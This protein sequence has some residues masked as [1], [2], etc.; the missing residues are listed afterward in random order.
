MDEAPSS[1]LTYADP[2][3]YV[4]ALMGAAF[5]S[6]TERGRVWM[7]D[8]DR[9][10]LL[11]RLS[12]NHIER[13]RPGQSTATVLT[14]PT[15]RIIDLLTVY[16]LDDALLL[17]TSPGRGAAIT[18]YL[19]K[20]SFFN[21]KVQ[22]EDATATLGQLTLYGPQAASLLQ[23]LG[24]AGTTLPAHSI[25][26]T[27]W[28]E[29]PLYLARD[30]DLGESSFWVLAPPAPLAELT[31]ALREAGAH[32]L[33]AATHEVLRVEAGRGAYGRELSLEYLPLEAGLRYAMSFTKGCYVGQEIIARMENRGRL[34]RCLRGLRLAAPPILA[35]DAPLATLTAADTA[36]G[37]LTSFVVSP[38][39]GPL[40]LAY[41]HT[42]HS[43]PGTHL[44]V[45]NIAA[46]V[47]DL[48]FK[49]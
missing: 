40:G 19:R 26:L 12:T 47:V 5:V 22:V 41:V 16:A 2:V 43:A 29:A 20:N 14:T 31:A 36:V 37:V 4:A 39:Y 34:V 49:A 15:A 44:M 18:Q 28:R 11:H 24:V 6:S 32:E 17:V 27:T 10:A 23:N 30:P 33:D 9:A 7:R 45:A 25:V 13:L 38:R 42:A 48:P 1:A 21:D 3:V 8:R 46:E 35:T